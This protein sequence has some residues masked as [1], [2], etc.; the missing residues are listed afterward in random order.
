MANLA[1]L[2]AR[3]KVL[4][5]ELRK[6]KDIEEIIQLKYRYWRC[7]HSGLWEGVGDCFAKDAV[8]EFMPEFQM[9]GREAIVQFFKD[10]VNPITKLV[11]L[12]GHNPEIEITS[13]STARGRWQLDNIRIEAA[14]NAGSRMGNAYVEEYTKDE[15][16]WKIKSSKV[17]YLFRE[18]A[19]I[20]PFD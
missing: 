1:D 13:G 16:K 19:Q 20:E 8:C 9:Q 2:E 3:V 15:G 10:R 12:H 7:V 4:E 14:T 5:E 17:A 6:L 18:P 11:V